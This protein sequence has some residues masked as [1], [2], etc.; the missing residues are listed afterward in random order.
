[1]SSDD[2][3]TE[4][5]LMELSDAVTAA[6]QSVTEALDRQDGTSP[7]A[8][9]AIEVEIQRLMEDRDEAERQFNSALA[10]FSRDEDDDED[11]DDFFD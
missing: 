3:V 2:A 8:S 10:E 7:D 6:D 1:M 5:E 9:G 11:Y 4:T